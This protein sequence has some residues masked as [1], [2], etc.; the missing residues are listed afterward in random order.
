M[1]IKSNNHATARLYCIIKDFKHND[2]L[3]RGESDVINWADGKMTDNK[4]VFQYEPSE[5]NNAVRHLILFCIGSDK[6]YFNQFAQ[7]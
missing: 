5:F 6:S 3:S 4:D 2:I 7:L 1:T